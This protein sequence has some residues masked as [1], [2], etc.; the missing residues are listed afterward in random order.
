MRRA[1]LI[2][3]LVAALV[4]A[5]AAFAPATLASA[6]IARASRDTI[7]LAGAEGT[8][9]HG[10]G[11]LVAVS[12]ARLPLAWSLDPWPLLRGEVRLSLAPFDAAAPLPRGKISLYERA[13]AVRELD[14]ALPAEMLQRVADGTGVRA[15]GE[16]RV[17]STSLDWAR[18]AIRGA[19][20][21][22]WRDAHLS[23]GPG[24]AV[25]LG[26]LNVNLSGEGTELR[27]PIANDGG[28]VDVRGV[29]A[30]RPGG[31]DVSLLLTPRRSDDATITRIL[32]A[33]GTPEGAS[34]RVVLRAP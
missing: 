16:A 13:I 34:F 4:A 6:W 23:A 15:T 5:V 32:A 33:I 11:T 27:G 20:Q 24:A 3:A 17:T 14:V 29:A 30:W 8:L 2:L 7:V 9:W 10:R 22:D 12:D 19:V 31:G 18:D 25:G 21:I 1:L 26:T 28:D